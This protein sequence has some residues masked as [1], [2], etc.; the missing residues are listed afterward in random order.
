MT[1][2]ISTALRVWAVALRPAT[3]QLRRAGASPLEAGDG[4]STG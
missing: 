4:G 1:T 2:V 3:R